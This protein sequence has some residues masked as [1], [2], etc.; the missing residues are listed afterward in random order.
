MSLVLTKSRFLKGRQC[1]RRLWL[2]ARE[3][4]EPPVESPDVWDER[5]MEGAAVEA[6]AE[7]LFDNPVHIGESDDD[8]E[9]AA[10]KPTFDERV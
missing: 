1:P 7:R 10:A 2:A 5:E 4:P 6:L 8:D 9:V 3:V